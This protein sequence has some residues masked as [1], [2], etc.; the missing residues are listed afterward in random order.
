MLTVAFL[1]DAPRVAGSEVWL[2]SVL[3]GLL[4]FGIRPAVFLPQSP[5]L[6]EL[7]ARMEAAGLPVTR[8]A[9]LTDLP[10]LTRDFDLRIMQVWDAGTYPKLLPTLTAP[11][12]VMVHDQLE[13]HYPL[14]LRPWYRQVYRSTKGPGLR[15]ADGVL[16][17]SNWGEAFLRQQFGVQAGC[18]PNGVDTERYRPRAEPERQALRSDFGFKRFTVLVPGRMALEKN[19]LAAL[20]TARLA[21]DLDFVFVGDMDSPL[22]SLVQRLK[23]FW[24]LDNVRLLGKRWDMPELYAAAD[25]LLQPTLAENQSLVTLEAMASGLSV[26]SSAIPAQAELITDGVD[27]LLLPPVPDLL[28]RTLRFLAAHPETVKKLG[29][30]A[31]ARVLRDHAL[32]ATAAALAPLLHRAANRLD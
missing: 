13:Y 27:G 7:A 24:K 32:S 20:R 21:R 16:T 6:D 28:A 19:Q 17:V 29:E 9:N 30:A 25:A 4:E 14:G 31:R 3:P 26:V 8:F 12:W 2:L 11:R 10:T 5:A 15:S 18:V 22:G 1:T 23:T